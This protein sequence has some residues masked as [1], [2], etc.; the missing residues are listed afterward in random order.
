MNELLEL[1]DS[2][3]VRAL[4]E[5]GNVILT[6]DPAIIHTSNGEPGSEAGEVWVQVL[7]LRFAGELIREGFEALCGPVHILDGSVVLLDGSTRENVVP[8]DALQLGLCTI[9]LEVI[10]DGAPMHLRITGRLTIVPVGDRVFL[11]EFPGSSVRG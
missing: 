5:N 6:L 9:R 4:N 3:I 1:H 10:G 7:E 2:V 11:E 8:L